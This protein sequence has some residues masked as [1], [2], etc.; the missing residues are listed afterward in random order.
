MSCLFC[1]NEVVDA[2]KLSS[3]IACLPSHLIVLLLRVSELRCAHYQL[4]VW[5]RSM[6]VLTANAC[7][8]FFFYYVQSG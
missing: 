5:T 4:D 7:V 3:T 6:Y 8:Y 2:G 1:E